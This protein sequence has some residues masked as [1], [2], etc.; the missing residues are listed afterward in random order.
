MGPD[1]ARV[2]F[3]DPRSRV[4]SLTDAVPRVSKTGEEGRAQD[5][6]MRRELGRL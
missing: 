5:P 3:T 6:R 4:Q 1:L 2:K